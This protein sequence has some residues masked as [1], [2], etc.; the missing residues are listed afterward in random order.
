MPAPGRSVGYWPGQG[1]DEVKRKMSVVPA[2]L[3]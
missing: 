1:A 2:D 3:E